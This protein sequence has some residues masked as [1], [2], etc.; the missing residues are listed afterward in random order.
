MEKLFSVRG[1]HATV[2]VELLHLI[3]R[4]EDLHEEL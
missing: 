1:R 4:M 2:V 3:E